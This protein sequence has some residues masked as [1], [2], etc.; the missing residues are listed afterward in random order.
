[1]VDTR[2]ASTPTKNTKDWTTEA[3]DAIERA[4]SAVRDKTV[5]PA[6]AI[7]RAIVYGLLATLFAVPALL[8][9]GIGFFRGLV[10]AYQGEV[11]AAWLTLGGIC[12]LLGGLSW[13][14]RTA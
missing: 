10:L 9:L 5:V 1:M 2:T 12:V 13:S 4:V 8:L 14:K 6:H 7:S 11:W 3:T